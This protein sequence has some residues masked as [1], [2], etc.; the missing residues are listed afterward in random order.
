LDLKLLKYTLV[1]IKTSLPLI[2]ASF[3]CQAFQKK[4]K[5]TLNFTIPHSLNWHN[6]KKLR[7][8][9]QKGLRDG[10]L[11]D[12]RQDKKIRTEGPLNDESKMFSA[13]GLGR[14]RFFFFSSFLGFPPFSTFAASGPDCVLTR[15]RTK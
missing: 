3:G 9:R 10:I 2:I 7:A 12:A 15:I 13:L 4:K 11:H 6:H 8:C 1:S 5:K 14:R